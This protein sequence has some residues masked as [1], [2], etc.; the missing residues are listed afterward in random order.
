MAYLRLS[1]SRGASARAAVA[2]S[3]RRLQ[4]LPA[5]H[6]SVWFRDEDL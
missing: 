4:R 6:R 2:G 3:G 5:D 1:I